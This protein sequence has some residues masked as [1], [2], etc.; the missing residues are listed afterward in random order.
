MMR[1][2]SWL[3]LVLLVSLSLKPGLEF[4]SNTIPT[5]TACCAT[6]CSAPAG[7]ENPQE[8]DCSDG[9]C[10]PFQICG[11]CVVPSPEVPLTLTV[12]PDVPITYEDIWL[13]EFHFDVLLPH[14]QP[15]KIQGA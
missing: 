9:Q 12:V 2:F 6:Q 14:W 10:N 11:Q 8:K 1:C 15:P 13:P 3:F 7:D 4:C 5:E